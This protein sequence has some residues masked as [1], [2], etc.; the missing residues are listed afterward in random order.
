MQALMT[1]M[2]TGSD[3][4]RHNDDITGCIQEVQQSIMEMGSNIQAIDTKV[5]NLDTRVAD[6]E[7]WKQDIAMDMQKWKEKRCRRPRRQPQQPQQ[8]Q[9]RDHPLHHRGYP[10]EA[11]SHQRLR[12]PAGGHESYTPEVSPHTEA[13]RATS[14]TRRSAAPF[15]TSLPT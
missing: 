6:M 12:G 3:L 8:V 7:T 14:S 11:P 1:N 9:P 5:Q 15:R 4:K 13:Q 10:Q 2:A